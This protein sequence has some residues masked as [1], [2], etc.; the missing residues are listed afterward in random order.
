[1]EEQTLLRRNDDFKRVVIEEL[2]S[3]G[4]YT[5]EHDRNPRKALAEII[6]WNVSVAL[7]PLVSQQAHE[8]VE[9]GRREARWEPQ[10]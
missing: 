4:I 8:L 6:E 2:I 1:M 3:I 10:A 5:K 9:R 7:D